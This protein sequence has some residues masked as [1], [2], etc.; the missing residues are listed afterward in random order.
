MATLKK[1][2]LV[3]SI[4]TQR[5]LDLIQEAIIMVAVDV[6]VLAPAL[7]LAPVAVE[8]VVLEKISMEPSYIQKI[9]M[10]L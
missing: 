5:M 8:L 3:R 2:V 9:Y 6:P 1:E 4:I 7:V 10:K